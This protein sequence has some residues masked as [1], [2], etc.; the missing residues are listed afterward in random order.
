MIIFITFLRFYDTTELR[1]VVDMGQV[2]SKNFVRSPVWVI[3]NVT[4]VKIPSENRFYLLNIDTNKTYKVNEIYYTFTI[5]RKPMYIMMNGIFPCFLLNLV[6]LLAFALPFATQI[7]LC[8][9]EMFVFI[10]VYYLSVS[11]STSCNIKGMTSFMTFA[12][13][14]LRIS[15]DIPVQSEYMPL[16]TLYMLFSIGYTFMGMSWLNI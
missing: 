1:W 16:L 8:K 4:Q 7:G 11:S 5:Q 10:Y 13:T 3:T 6:I 14:S 12:V 15:T 2:L 9:L